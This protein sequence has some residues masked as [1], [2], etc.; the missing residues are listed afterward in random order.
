MTQRSIQA[1]KTPTVIIRVGGDVEIQGRDDARVVAR[2]DSHWGLEIGQ[3][4]KSQV[5]RMR[6]RVGERVLFDV[7]FNGIGGK[8]QDD[9][10]AVQVKISASGTVWVPSGSSVKVYAGKNVSIQNLFGNVTVSAG[11]NV[12]LRNVRTLAHASAGGAMDLD[13]ETLVA[14][15]AKFSSGHALRFNIHDLQNARVIVNDIG[16][17]WEGVLGSGERK[18]RLIAGGDAILVTRQEVKAQP[19]DYV[20]GNIETPDEHPSEDKP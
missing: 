7:S 11:G 1:G 8:K 10:N 18:I 4:S 9:P 2:T 19:P 5:A 16:G 14:G 13:C 12:Q 15:D 6:A 17:Y 3:G 20:L